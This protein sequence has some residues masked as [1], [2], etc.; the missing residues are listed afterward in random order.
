M[1]SESTKEEKPAARDISSSKAT[2]LEM[3]K[4]YPRAIG[5]AWRCD[6]KNTVLGSLLLIPP[7]AVPPAQFWLSKQI[8]DKIIEPVHSAA[9]TKVFSLLPVWGFVGLQVL[10]RIAGSA[11]EA[12]LI[13]VQSD[14]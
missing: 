3:I 5:L 13:V 14:R 12:L 1:S 11:M 10:T 9:A 4:L 6:P 8:I 7:P 2:V